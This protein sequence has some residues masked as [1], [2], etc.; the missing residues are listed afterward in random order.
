MEVTL[1]LVRLPHTV[2]L[3]CPDHYYVTWS[4]L[5]V[6]KSEQSLCFATTILTHLWWFITHVSYSMTQ[7]LNLVFFLTSSFA[8]SVIFPQ[9]TVNPVP[10]VSYICCFSKMWAA[11]RRCRK[12][13]KG[14]K[15][16]SR[17]R[18]SSLSLPVT[19]FSVNVSLYFA[20]WVIQHTQSCLIFLCVS[21]GFSACSSV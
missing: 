7:T 16:L 10:E 3:F 2:F 17:I 1:I 19:F 12:K 13:E 21:F 8:F 9:P 5:T 6:W 18:E 14:K 4:W 20:Y 11:K 15:K